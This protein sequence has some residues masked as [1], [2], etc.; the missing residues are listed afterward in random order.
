MKFVER[1]ICAFAICVASYTQAQ[2]T[3][4]FQIDQPAAPLQINAGEDQVF[5]GT[6]PVVLGGQPTAFGANGNYTYLWSPAEFLDDPTAPNP[7]VI[8]LT[9]ATTFTVI[10]TAEGALCDK[11]DEVFVDF[12][13]GVLSRASSELH[14][15]PNPF[16]DQVRFESSS[17]AL[18]VQVYDIAG[19]RVLSQHASG[20]TNGLIDTSVLESGLYFFGFVFMNGEQKTLRLC[21]VN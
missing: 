9:V 20:T 3:L 8:G 14:V 17:T 7:E 10:V 1:T 21:K 18:S 15:F 6:N 19:N 16:T 13:S 11:T 4:Q 2:T 5:E 12:T